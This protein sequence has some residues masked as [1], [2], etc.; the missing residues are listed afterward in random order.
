MLPKLLRLSMLSVN[1]CLCAPD[2]RASL[3]LSVPGH[4]MP[5]DTPGC[6]TLL[7]TVLAH[8]GATSL[9]ATGNA[10]MLVDPLDGALSILSMILF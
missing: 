9:G 7:L 6:S 2:N 8:R 1:L 5:L 3:S 10:T 4:S